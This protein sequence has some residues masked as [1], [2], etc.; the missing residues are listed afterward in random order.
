MSAMN[1]G[2]GQAAQRLKRRDIGVRVRVIGIVD[3]RAVINDISPERMLPSLLEQADSGRRVSGRVDLETEIAKN[4][5]VAIGEGDAGRAPARSG[6]VRLTS[7]RESGRTS[8]VA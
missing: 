5:H 3:Q 4:D 8:F 2:D 7:L 6:S 1:D